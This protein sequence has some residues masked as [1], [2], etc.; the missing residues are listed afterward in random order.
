[1]F[2]KW[3]FLTPGVLASSW[4]MAAVSLAETD[5][6]RKMAIS[7]PPRHS[8]DALLMA[9]RMISTPPRAESETATVMIAEKVM[10]RLRRRLPAVSRA[11]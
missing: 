1:M 4:P 7:T 2:T 10:T 11:T 8:I 5:G 9:W 3:Y 6:W